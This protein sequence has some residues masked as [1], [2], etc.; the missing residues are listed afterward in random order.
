MH[1]SSVLERSR[2]SL[3]DTRV[4]CHPVLVNWSMQSLVDWDTCVEVRETHATPGDKAKV[5]MHKWLPLV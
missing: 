4:N 1:H 3:I 2:H 5:S